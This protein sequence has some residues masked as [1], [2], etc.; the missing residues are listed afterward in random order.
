MPGTTTRGM[1]FRL[2]PLLLSVYALL[3]RERYLDRAPW[4]PGRRTCWCRILQTRPGRCIRR[5]ERITGALRRITFDDV[6]EVLDGW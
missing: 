6:P 5:M 3:I 4:P 1:Y 2:R